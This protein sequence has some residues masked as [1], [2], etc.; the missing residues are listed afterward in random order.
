MNDEKAY[1]S[2]LEATN[3]HRQNGLPSVQVSGKKIG[4]YKNIISK[5]FTNRIPVSDYLHWHD[6]N[7]LVQRL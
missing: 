7:E 4:K 1:K 2:I 5:F 3:A 6:T